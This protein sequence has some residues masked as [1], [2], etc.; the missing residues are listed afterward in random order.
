MRINNGRFAS[1]LLFTV[2]GVGA[3]VMATG[4]DIGTP[5]KMGPGFF[6]FAVAIIMTLL[7]IASLFQSMMERSPAVV[8]AVDITPLLMIFAG[9]LSFAFLIERLGLVVSIGALLAF[10]CYRQLC[11][12]PLEVFGIFV[13]LAAVASVLCVYLFGMPV[14]VLP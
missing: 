5:L 2:I 4:Y 14:S 1:G 9:M 3:G 6:P 10:A 13:V 7:G 11:D 8:E 12:K